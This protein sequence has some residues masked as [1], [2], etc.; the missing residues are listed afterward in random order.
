MLNAHTRGDFTLLKKKATPKAKTVRDI[1]RYERAEASINLN[2]KQ[3]EAYRNI[4]EPDSISVIYGEAGVGKTISG[5]YAGF[6]LLK[7][8]QISRIILT[9]PTVEVG[10]SMGFLPG[11]MEEKYMPYLMPFK[12]F[13]TLLGNSGE[14]TFDSMMVTKQIVPAPLQ[15]LQGLTFTETDLV[16]LDEA[17]NATREEI[18]MVLGRMKEGS[19]LVINGDTAQKMTKRNES[20]GLALSLHLSTK[21]EYIKAFELTENK[22][23]P[24]IREI[25]KTIEEHE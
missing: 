8:R 10:R 18:S 13:C 2:E 4:L 1:P 12:D 25:M 21:L 11:E 17:Q 5:I 19:R 16:I 15:F 24:R 20:N 3:N 22:R 9:R 23:H 14:A 7:M 6:K